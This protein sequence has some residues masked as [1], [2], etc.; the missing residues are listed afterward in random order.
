MHFKDYVQLLI[1]YK[2]STYI[3]S[4]VSEIFTYI[5]FMP[6]NAHT[7]VSAT[8]SRAGPDSFNR[9]K[10]LMFINI[11]SH[12]SR[13]QYWIRDSNCSGQ[14]TPRYVHTKQHLR[15]NWR[16]S[17]LPHTSLHHIQKMTFLAISLR[18]NHMELWRR[19]SMIIS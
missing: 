10:D 11:T 15:S 17:K 6:I 16:N 4:V 19:K 5:L 3:I 2:V 7:F 12:L 8:K 9:K 18:S 14:I 1:V 13:R